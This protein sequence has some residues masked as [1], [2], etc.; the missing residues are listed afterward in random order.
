MLIFVISFIV[1]FTLGALVLDALEGDEGAQELIICLLAG[2]VIFYLFLPTHLQDL[3][4][5][6]EDF[7]TWLSYFKTWWS[8]IDNYQNM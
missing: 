1:H 4:L 5:L 6:F 8:S 2:V 7:E 3:S